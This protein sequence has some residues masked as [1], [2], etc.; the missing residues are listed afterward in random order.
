MGVPLCTCT[1]LPGCSHPLP[2]HLPLPSPLPLLFPLPRPP[3]PPTFLLTPT[4]QVAGA[5]SSLF[6]LIIILKLGELFQDLPKVS[7][8]PTPT[9]PGLG[10]FARPQTPI[11]QVL[12]KGEGCRLMSCFFQA[13]NLWGETWS[14]GS[15]VR[16]FPS[17]IQAV[18][19]RGQQVVGAIWGSHP[20]A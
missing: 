3:I 12:G 18:R 5:I 16:P 9:P 8:R 15:G 17:Q 7:P 13:C 14:Q 6:I 20:G 10:A 19:F 4:A 1:A 2:S 11:S